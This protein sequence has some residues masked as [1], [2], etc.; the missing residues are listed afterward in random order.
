MAN[1]LFF[2]DNPLLIY[3]LDLPSI[4]YTFI[5]FVFIKRIMTE[6]WKDIKGYEGFYQVSNIGKIRSVDRLVHNPRYGFQKLKG[7][8]LSASPN[9]HGYPQ[10]GLTQKGKRKTL[11]VHSL[12]ALYFLDKISNKNE[13]NHKDG[14][15]LNNRVENL[16]WCT[17]SENILHAFAFDL[18]EKPKGE[19]NGQSK[20]TKAEVIEIR[21]MYKGRGKGLSLAK[22]ALIYNL[23]STQVSR[24]IKKQ[25]WRH[26]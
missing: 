17:R 2:L 14:D 21:E 26:V 1:I 22:I 8:L 10:I 6:I 25:S 4:W 9:S 13:V 15:K 5:I 23:G 24:I 3:F 12:V 18:K 11:K 7:K 19:L 20:I 16:E